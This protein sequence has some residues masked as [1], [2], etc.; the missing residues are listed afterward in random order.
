MRINRAK[1]VEDYVSNPAEFIRKECWIFNPEKDP[2]VVPF[3]LF[4]YQEEFIQD[5][6]YDY[7][8]QKDV[9]DEKSRQMGLSWLYM[10]FFLWG[11]LYDRSFTGFTMSY[12]ETL[13]DDGG[14][15]S[16]VN[17]LFGKLRFMYERL[18]KSPALLRFKYLRVTNKA[19]G[20]YLV[21]ESTN[22]N[23][24]R[25]GTYKIGLWDETAST[26]KSEVIFPAFHQAVRCRCFNSTV[27]GKGNVFSRL[28]WDPNSGVDI[29]TFH[30]T[31]H[32]EKSEEKERVDGKWTS[33]WY[34]Q[35]CRELT[36]SQVAQELD[37]DYE[38]S[39]EGRVY[40]KLSSQVHVKDIEFNPAW[41]ERSIIAW[42]LGVSDETFGI[43]LQQDNQ[44]NIAVVDEVVGTDEEIRFY[45]SL[46][47]GVEP[48]EFSFMQNERKKTFT[49]FLKRAREFQYKRLTQVA[50]PDAVQRS[51]TS[52][53]SVKD[54]FLRAVELGRDVG[55]GRLTD[56][57][58]TNMRMI[59]LT[60]YKIMD[61]IVAVKKVIDPVRNRV[62][63]S[64]RCVNLWERLMNY[65]WSQSSEGT[66][67]ETP[68]HDWASHGADAFGYGVLYLTRHRAV[69][70]KPDL[71]R[72]G[73][74]R[75]ARPGIISTLKV[76]S[77]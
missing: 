24:G 56:R 41:T 46:V 28:R 8:K 47:C 77:R 71:Y 65:K 12:K 15:E 40:G 66:N 1:E 45:I 50:G 34:E 20:A 7:Q 29:K 64:K 14:S 76:G 25:G 60:G 49:D 4:P 68:E 33:P 44:G 38:T 9:L 6:H 5:L 26:P 19:T 35:Q 43:V 58:Y 63:I 21:G 13:V 39:A 17:S 11:L 16:T 27:R 32:P 57:R 62:I 10:A 53:R 18:K 22:P 23:A 70:Q 37:I 75:T 69:M 48:K 42:D 52:K 67:K 74:V 31:L 3:D 30:W 55:S 51:I 61:R 72:G 59:A 54:Q 73:R 2:P 36:P